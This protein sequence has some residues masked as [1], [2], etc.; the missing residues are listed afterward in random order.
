MSSAAATSTNY[1]PEVLEM[2]EAFLDE[3][4]REE[5]GK[6]ANKFP[7]E[8]QSLVVDWG[9]LFRFDTEM[10]WDATDNPRQIRD[11]LEEALARFDLPVAV[12]LSDARVR[13]TNLVAD[14]EMYVGEYEPTHTEELI[15]LTGQV[16]QI[17]QSLP[18]IVTAEYECQRCGT[19]TTIPQAGSDLQEPHECGGCERQGPFR[20]DSSESTFE[21]HQMVRLELPPDVASG[22]DKY[23]DVHL[24]G[25]VAEQLDGSERATITGTLSIDEDDTDGRDFPWQFDGDDI[26]VEEGGFEDLQY[27]EFEDEIDEIAAK[28]DPVAYLA[29]KL[30]PDLHKDEKMELV[31]EALVCGMVGASREGGIRA[32]SHMLMMGDP[33]TGKSELLEAV[34]DKSPRSRYASGESVSGAGLTAAAER[35]DFGPGEWTVKAGLLPRTNDGVVC[36]DELDKITDVDKQKLHSA[37]EKQQIDFHKAGQGAHLA[38]RTGLIAAGNPKHGRF[39]PHMNVAE[40]IDL[41][42]T[43]LSRFDLI[44]TMIDNPDP[45]R[46][47]KIADVALEKWDGGNADDGDGFGDVFQAYIAYAREQVNPEPTE[48]AKQMIKR[49]YVEIRSNS[50]NDDESPVPLT[51]RK[52]E[53]FMRVAESAARVRLSETVERQDAKRAIKLVE[54]SLND[55]GIDPETGEFDADVIE[56]GTSKSQRDR[57]RSVKGIIANIEEEY[58][59]GAPVDVVMDRAM[60]QNIGKNKTEHEIEQLKDKGELYEPR[61]DHLRTT[62]S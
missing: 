62:K 34:H 39:D 45:G 51:A 1:Y 57:I 26:R 59:D 23:I 31:S 33:G 18:R 60:E 44:F 42:P 2:C 49:K 28:D 11:H 46:D 3:H 58:D 54:Q 12:D 21:K 22:A 29:D 16:R 24:T 25:D 15:G 5:I 10:A 53:A 30:H 6:L 52:L 55:V 20:L 40:Q 9:L 43:M 41:T 19:L 47:E 4:Y 48:T 61:T 36:M 27:E 56:T 35:T 32:D 37:L 17:S 13:Y 14:R 50:Y 7:G 38:S 8:Q